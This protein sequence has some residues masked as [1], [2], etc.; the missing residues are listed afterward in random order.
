MNEEQR[1]VFNGIDLMTGKYLIPSKSLEEFSELVRKKN[2]ASNHSM[3]LLR[4]RESWSKDRLGVR[5]GINPLELDEAGWGIIFPAEYDAATLAALKA[6]LAPLLK[7]RKQQ[8]GE[9][10]KEFSGAKTGY[11][12][13]DTYAK[14]LARNRMSPAVQADPPVVPYYLLLVGSPEDIPF[15]FQFDLDV[16]YAVGRLYFAPEEGENF[17]ALL[18]KYAHYARGV[19]ESENGSIPRE[20]KAAFFGTRHN[21]DLSTAG[22]TFMLV[23]PLLD[24]LQRKLPGWEIAPY[25][26]GQA[27]RPCLARLAND[28]YNSSVLF[29]A[30]HGLA[31][32]QPQE[33]FMP[34]GQIAHHY[35]AHQKHQG[36]LLCQEWPGP[37]EWGAANRAIPEHFYFSADD[38]RSDADL[39]GRIFFHFACNSAGITRSPSIISS[40]TGVE[41]LSNLPQRLLG[42]PT[43][44]ALAVIGN[45]GQ[46]WGYSFAWKD[47][48][49]QTS[50]FVDVLHQILLGE[51]IGK[52]TESLNQHYAALAVSLESMLQDIEYFRP[53][54][55]DDLV[56]MWTANSDA[57][58]YVVLGD[59]AVKL[60]LIP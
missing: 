7:L 58:S 41:R 33:S 28:S 49:K 43:G 9:V 37:L 42:H 1:L 60:S 52:A 46:V 44:G 11:R 50:T 2:F 6:A 39:R 15:R 59:P 38:I 19:V 53:P 32:E 8:A 48:G 47:A 30:S 57:R 45:V 56:G 22:S 51:R 34:G 13:D 24:E 10:Y 5:Y 55:K 31:V 40:T 14:W 3:A 23:E 26:E 16:I 35:V 25:L 17:D 54:D 20:R 12:R 18:E 27:T 29:T 21:D 36:A 4:L